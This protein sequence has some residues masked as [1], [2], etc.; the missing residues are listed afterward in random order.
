MFHIFGQDALRGDGTWSAR[1]RSTAHQPATEA[2]PTAQPWPSVRTAGVVLPA[3]GTA[4]ELLPQTVVPMAVGPLAPGRV[5]C[6]GARV[7]ASDL[8]SS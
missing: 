1:Q 6:G 4:P 7:A 2:A 3:A 5:P 8:K